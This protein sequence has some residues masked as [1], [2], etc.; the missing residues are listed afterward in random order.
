M[1]RQRIGQYRIVEEIATG[2]QGVIYRA[3]DEVNNRLVAI[4]IPELGRGAPDAFIERFRREAEVMSSID[5]PNVVKIYDVGVEDGRHYLAMELMPGSLFSLIES[6]EALP[7]ASAV[8]FAIQIADGLSAAHSVGVVHRDIKPQNVLID[9]DGVAKVADFGI[10]RGEMMPTMTATGAM[11]GTPYYMSPEQ[12][13]GEQADSRSDIYSMGCVLYQMLTGELVFDAPT[14]LAVLRMHIDEAPTPVRELRGD[15]PPAIAAVVMRALRKDPDDRFQTAAEMAEALQFP[16]ED[17]RRQRREEP[18]EPADSEGPDGEIAKE[19]AGLDRRATETVPPTFSPQRGAVRTGAEVQPEYRPH[20]GPRTVPPADPTGYPEEVIEAAPGG[21]LSFVSAALLIWGAAL[22]IIGFA[23][24]ASDGGSGASA[25]VGGVAGLVAGVFVLRGARRRWPL[26]LAIMS[27]IL[28][29]AAI[30]PSDGEGDGG[31]GGLVPLALRPTATP[32]A[33]A[34][35][36]PSP[37]PLPRPTVTVAPV[38]LPTPSPTNIPTP[39]PLII[40]V[41]PTPLPTARPTPTPTPPPTP[42]PTPTPAPTPT[43]Q[44]PPT[45]TPVPADL[46]VITRPA[47]SGIIGQPIQLVGASTDSSLAGD[48]LVAIIDWGDGSV[49]KF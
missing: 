47:L 20:A 24:A 45:A 23:V 33:T 14:P 25:I 1:S 4:K 21:G 39:T 7:V 5:H 44:P 34:T 46:T 2:A 30:P 38:I 27:V 49:T 11:M 35:A 37:T 10:A 42:T 9:A 41:T 17:E 22:V 26:S 15:I 18:P 48:E 8:R 13:A 16:E 6:G 32:V 29:I 19:A 12:A 36:T 31:D 40:R 43:P 28:A 3:F